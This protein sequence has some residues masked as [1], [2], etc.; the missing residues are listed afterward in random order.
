MKSGDYFFVTSQANGC[1]IFWK[2]KTVCQNNRN[3]GS[4]PVVTLNLCSP[5]NPQALRL[6]SKTCGFIPSVFSSSPGTQLRFR[7]TL[8]TISPATKIGESAEI[9]VFKAFFVWK[10]KCHLFG[11][12][13]LG[14]PKKRKKQCVIFDFWM[15][16][17]Y[18]YI[19]SIYHQK[20]TVFAHNFSF[21]FAT[22]GALETFQG[23]F[24]RQFG[25]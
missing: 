25:P 22:F 11:G 16:F 2:K 23:C 3:Q 4:T 14:S 20:T 6:S 17:Q 9:C 7:P 10:K 19:N 1:R 12:R 15:G 13:L 21:F 18:Q 24:C 5:W 8:V